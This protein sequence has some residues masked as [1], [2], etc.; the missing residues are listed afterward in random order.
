MLEPGELDLRRFQELCAEGRRAL[1]AG[2]AERAAERLGAALAE[3]RGAPL[4]DLAYEPF[5]QAQAARLEEERLAALEDR[6]EAALRLGRHAEVVGELRRSSRPS[7]CGNARGQLMLALYRCG[8]QSE[9][10]EAFRAGA[11]LL[12]EEPGCA[13]RPSSCA[14]R[15]RSCARTPAW[16]SP[17]RPCASPR[18]HRGCRWRARCAATTSRRSSVAGR[19]GDGAG[20]VGGRAGGRLHAVLL[21][22]EPGIG[23]TRLAGELAT[24][25]ATGGGLVLYGR[26]DETLAAPGR[27]VV[28]LLR[29]YTEGCPDDLLH[30][31]LGPLRG[32]L[33]P[34]LP[35][36][37]ER[38]AGLAASPAADPETE[39]ARVLD[40]V[41]SVL[42][43][44]GEQT[45]VLVVLDDLQWA[46]ELTLLAVRRLLA[47]DAPRRI[48]LVATLRDTEAAQ[49][50]LLED[51]LADAARHPAWERCDLAGLA[52]GDVAALAGR[53]GDGALA[54]DV[55]AATSGNPFFAGELLRA[56]AEAGGGPRLRP[57]AVPRGVLGLLRTRLA[58]MA[59]A[60]ATSCR[61]RPSWA[62]RSS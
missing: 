36:L 61:P 29:A 58:R 48:L 15:R 52:V 27:P 26:C 20:G 9:A 13:R 23:K 12:D 21:V 33:L 57:L 53:D 16:T 51:L 28:E 25:V 14:W 4:C 45:P 49:H 6:F 39:R 24:H 17:R 42:R 38:L 8:R 47:Q 44:A 1:A 55:H 30:D 10:L 2:H 56:H 11:A 59:P 3:W 31:L 35:E 62:G 37:R 60:P 41:V 22:G 43:R 46:D 7:R 50:G 54:A 5:A 40:A 34:L 19:A 32:D 18:P